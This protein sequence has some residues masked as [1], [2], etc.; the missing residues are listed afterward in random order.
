MFTYSQEETNFNKM[1]DAEGVFSYDGG[2]ALFKM[3]ADKADKREKGILE[4]DIPIQTDRGSSSLRT[5]IKVTLQNT[6]EKDPII[7]PEFPKLP[8]KAP[9][10]SKKTRKVI[11]SLE[12]TAPPKKSAQDD[13]NE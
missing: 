4:F 9:A 12:R 5:F 3:L 7:L 2:W 6:D 11:N 8:E 13:D 10:L 1:S